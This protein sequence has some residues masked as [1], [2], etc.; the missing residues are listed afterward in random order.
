M[1]FGRNSPLHINNQEKETLP[2]VNSLSYTRIETE[3]AGEAI[4][5]RED[6]VIV[7]GE[8]DKNWRS[9]GYWGCS[10]DEGLNR[11]CP[12]ARKT[13]DADA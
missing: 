13:G 8:R 2:E 1:V 5:R 10:A 12:E 3:R 9:G 4:A 11:L 7:R 6:E